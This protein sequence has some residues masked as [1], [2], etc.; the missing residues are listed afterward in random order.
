MYVVAPILMAFLIPV[1]FFLLQF[2]TAT[3]MIE[4]TMKLVAMSPKYYFQEG[5][6][7]FDFIIV[8]LSLLEM[9]LEGVQ[10]LSVLRSFRLV[11]CKV[12]TIRKRFINMIFNSSAKSI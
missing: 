3:F 11:S 8:A 6:N 5:W 4:A 2:F 12:E 1:H 10:G 9:G 7:I